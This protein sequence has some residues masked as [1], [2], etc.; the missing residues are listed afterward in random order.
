MNSNATMFFTSGLAGTNAPQK[1][2]WAQAA[3]FEGSNCLVYIRGTDDEDGDWWMSGRV[4]GTRVIG[5]GGTMV[6]AHFDS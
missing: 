3:Y 4:H 6:N 5:K 1:T 2:S